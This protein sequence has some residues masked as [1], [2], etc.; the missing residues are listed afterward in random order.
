MHRPS[1]HSCRPAS[2][3]LSFRC[4]A[5]DHC[6]ALSSLVQVDV[7]LAAA[8]AAAAAGRIPPLGN[9]ATARVYLYRGTKDVVCAC[10]GGGGGQAAPCAH[11]P[12]CPSLLADPDGSVNRTAEFFAALAADPAAQV[13]F[14]ASI[15]SQH[16]MPTVDPWLSPASCGVNAPWAPPAMEN[17]GYDGAGAALQHMYNGSLTP[18]PQGA[19]PDPTRL[20]AFDQTLY[21]NGTLFG[22]LATQGFVYVPAA[23]EPPAPASCRIHVAMHGCGMG[24]SF[25][26]MNS[27]FVLHAGYG[28]WADANGIVI[29]FPQGGYF[30]EHGLTAPAAQVGAGC[31]DGAFGGRVCAQRRGGGGKAQWLGQGPASAA[32][33]APPAGYG[34]TGPDYAFAGGPQTVQ[35]RNMLI[36][37]GGPAYA[38]GAWQLTQG[39]QS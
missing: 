14:E 24:Y 22:G 29:L 15:P 11:A 34:Q 32:A 33:P 17:C 7:L 8:E 3:R 36:A 2:S 30:H 12:R 9:L 37:L 1:R 19:G 26:A 23:C 25:A 35:I 38:P 16:C 28:P 18:P 6:K 21:L 39:A 20:F 27:S 10:P 31:F 13:A 5:D 4:L